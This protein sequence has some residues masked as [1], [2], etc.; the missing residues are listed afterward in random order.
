MEGSWSELFEMLVAGEIDL[1]SD[2]SY[3]E[4]RAQ[5]IL[6]SAEGMGS[7]D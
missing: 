6:Y 5:K 1:L 7:E 3:T 4:E 2:V